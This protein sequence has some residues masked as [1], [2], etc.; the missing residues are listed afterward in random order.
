MLGY[1]QRVNRTLCTDKLWL[2]EHCEQPWACVAGH[3]AGYPCTACNPEAALP[4]GYESIAH[5]QERP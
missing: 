2:C 3:G 1:P 4:V 5:T